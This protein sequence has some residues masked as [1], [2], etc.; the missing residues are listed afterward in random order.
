MLGRD[1]EAEN[2]APTLMQIFMEDNSN[3]WHKFLTL[4]N[5][6]QNFNT[7]AIAFFSE[8]MDFLTCL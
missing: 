5:L 8:A 2:T 4:W 7:C 3:I 1:T 6:L